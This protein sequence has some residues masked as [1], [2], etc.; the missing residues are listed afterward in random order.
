MV[1]GGPPR[2]KTKSHADRVDPSCLDVHHRH[3]LKDGNSQAGVNPCRVR[4]AGGWAEP[5]A[6]DNSDNPGFT[7]VH[8]K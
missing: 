6:R 4:D 1:S 5:Q 8:A 7:V 2:G 3:V